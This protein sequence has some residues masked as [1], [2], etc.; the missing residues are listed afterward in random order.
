MVLLP[1]EKTRSKWWVSDGCVQL[2]RVCVC[3]LVSLLN[4]QWVDKLIW[5]GFVLPANTANALQESMRFRHDSFRVNLLP[6]WCCCIMTSR[7]WGDSCKRNHMAVSTSAFCQPVIAPHY[8]SNVHMLRC[9]AIVVNVSKATIVHMVI[10][11][12]LSGRLIV[13]GETLRAHFIHSVGFL[14]CICLL[15]EWRNSWYL[16]FVIAWNSRGFVM[17]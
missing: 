3:G 13:P 8:S 5:L 6:P 2:L 11:H 17:K 12:H 1:G 15:A 7:C 16:D 14:I 4:H 10:S 9:S